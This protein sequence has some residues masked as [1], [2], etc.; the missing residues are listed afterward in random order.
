MR[1][2]SIFS[3]TVTFV[4]ALT[5]LIVITTIDDPGLDLECVIDKVKNYDDAEKITWTCLHY[6]A[7]SNN[8]SRL[9][10]MLQRGAGIDA[11]SLQGKTPIYEAAK[12]GMTEAVE[13]LHNNGADIN[14]RSNHPG[15]TPLH[16]AAEYNQHETVEY[17]LGQ[18]VDIDIQ[19]S[20]QQ[21]PLSQ[22]SWRYADTEMI[23]LLLE[24]G[25]DINTQD[26][27]GY[28]PLHRATGK[29]R[30][31]VM[32]FLISKKANINIKANKGLTPLMFAAWK[33]KIESVALLLESGAYIE[34][35]TGRRT[36]LA[37]AKKAGHQQIVSLL[38]EY[39]AVDT[40]LISKQLTTS[41]EHYKKEDFDESL[42]DLNKAIEEDPENAQSLY[43]RGRTYQK[44]NKLDLALNDLL[45]SVKL[46]P[47]NTE[48]LEVIAWLYLNRGNHL[49]SINYYSI[50]LEQD[51]DNAKAYHNRAGL[52][53][54]LGDIEKAKVDVNIACE[55]GYSDACKMQKKLN[56]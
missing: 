34:K 6:A 16:V 30:L 19:N 5:A 55:K 12:R 28:S 23:R 37:M 14:T 9:T 3:G 42:S 22:S 33:G 43:Y 47:N 39:G 32:S 7:A 21:T 51:P 41:Y 49:E 46:D 29:E 38:K 8:T 20:W 45:A 18:N 11:G 35:R 48:A 4:I 44:M 56:N 53:A 52:Y 24:H 26:N 13:L 54:R 36:S 25:A 10:S 27:N 2:F 17:L 1:V 15:F 40:S 50:V 31:E